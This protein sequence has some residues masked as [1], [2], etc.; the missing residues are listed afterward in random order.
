MQQ[1]LAIADADPAQKI[2]K[3]MTVFDPFKVLKVERYE[4]RHTTTLAWLLDPRQNHGLG[5]TF[6]HH[7]LEQ[8]LGEIPSTEQVLVHAELALVDKHLRSNSSFTEQE[9]NAQHQ[10]QKRKKGELDILIEGDSWAVA[11]EAKIDS[12]EG[13][14]QLADYQFSLSQRYTKGQHTLKMLYLTVDEDC[15]VINRNPDWQNIQWSVEV[16]TALRKSLTESPAKVLGQGDARSYFLERYLNLICGLGGEADRTSANELLCEFADKH[17]EA[18]AALKKALAEKQRKDEPVNPWSGAGWEQVYWQYQQLFDR[19]IEVARKPQADFLDKVFCKLE[20]ASGQKLKAWSNRAGKAATLRFVP[21]SWLAMKWAHGNAEVK[22]DEL[23]HYHLAFREHRKDV[24]LKLY[25][26][27]SVKKPAQIDLLKHFLENIGS[28]PKGAITCS[29]K[30]VDSFC[31]PSR[32]ATRAS[33]KIYSRSLKWKVD[34]PNSYDLT[35]PTCL[36]AFQAVMDAH[37]NALEKVQD[38]SRTHPKAFDEGREVSMDGV[39]AA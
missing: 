32:S 34:G 18:L 23:V 30:T 33:M 37:S 8:V 25:L 13:D 36:A 27:G 35:E 7:F 31:D 2:L 17:Y 5:H 3:Q 20:K 6:L 14:G 38:V 9:R 24:E 22:L 12:T 16:A 15:D 11:I 10:K 21:E 1:L 29:E 26:P 28:N 4:L 39:A 19:L